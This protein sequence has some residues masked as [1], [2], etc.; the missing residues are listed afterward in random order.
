V[1]SKEYTMRLIDPGV[2]EDL[3]RGEPRPGKLLRRR[4]APESAYDLHAVIEPLRQRRGLWFRLAQ[5]EGIEEPEMPHLKSVAVDYW[6]PP[7]GDSQ[8]Y[9]TVYLDEPDLEGVFTTLVNDIA[10]AVVL[11]PTP[12]EAILAIQRRLVRWE[13]L[14]SR[15]RRETLSKQEVKG[16]YGELLIMNSLLDSGMPPDSV[17]AG[18]AGPFA[19][20]Q[21][22][23]FREMAIEVKATTA[24]QP[25]ALII[26][27]ER[28]LDSVGVDRLLLA[29]VSLD[30]R[31]DGTG[32]SLTDLIEDTLARL[33][34]SPSSVVSL[35]VGLEAYGYS[36]DD[37]D[38][39]RTP[40]FSIR[41]LAYYEVV[42]HFPRIVE[43]MLPTGVGDVRYRIQLAGISD[44]K[45]S[46]I[47]ELPAV[48]GGESHAID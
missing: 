2:W 18:W 21:D 9:L 1:T 5:S 32:E 7:T 16:L 11:Q 38:L 35:T 8:R 4:L 37:A 20:V 19:G 24:K 48:D 25:Q 46:L 17:L 30:E 42:D 27:N 33:S 22:F 40:S 10:E 45:T 47:S 12:D 15:T 34:S 23:Q 3:E 28:E 26:T 14:L 6:T 43:A 36:K 29:H 39:H 31:L 41:E 13:R 44:F